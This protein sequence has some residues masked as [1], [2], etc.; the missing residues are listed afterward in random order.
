MLS[1]M[2][3]ILRWASVMADPCV[4]DERHEA[5]PTPS[6]MVV[7][8]FEPR[9]RLEHHRWRGP[10]VPRFRDRYQRATPVTGRGRFH[11]D[12]P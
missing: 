4:F 10:C 2:P 8:D 6:G 3:D 5:W 1:E 7:S 9:R 12:R 11:A